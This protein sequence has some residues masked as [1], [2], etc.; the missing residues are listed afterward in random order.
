M[1][2]MDENLI[3]RYRRLP[4]AKAIPDVLWDIER[5]RIAIQ[6]YEER[7]RWEIIAMNQATKV[8]MPILLADWTKKQL[9]EVGLW[10]TVIK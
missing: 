5:S 7:V 3:V 4:G 1:G 10:P 2:P 9:K 8:L 6:E